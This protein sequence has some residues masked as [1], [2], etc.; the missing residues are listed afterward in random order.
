MNFLSDGQ[1]IKIRLFSAIRGQVVNP[2]FSIITPYWVNPMHWCVPGMQSKAV[3]QGLPM[4]AL[5]FWGKQ[6]FAFVTM[7][8]QT[9]QEVLVGFHPL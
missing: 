5:Q 7:L 8:V 9:S 3:Q 2:G 6:V 4:P 1:S